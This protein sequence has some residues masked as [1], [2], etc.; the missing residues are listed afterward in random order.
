MSICLLFDNDGTLVDSERLS[1]I[2]YVRLF[3]NYDVA[4]DADELVT[5]Y[6][7][8][9]LAKIIEDIADEHNVIVSDNFIPQYRS[10]VADLF[11][12]ELKP[13]D[14]I[15]EALEQ[16]PYPKAVV[17]S[18][19]P[20]KIEQTLRICNL[21]DYFGKNIFSSYDLG[22][23]KPEP[24]IYL[25]AAKNMGY[26]PENCYAI[27]DSMAGLAA[28]SRAGMKTFFYNV[29]NEESPCESITSFT[30]MHDFPILIKNYQ[31]EQILV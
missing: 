8:M 26:S 1:S 4:L 5:K 27:E 7:G 17:S 31:T 18:G 12:Q 15:H 11:E 16:L 22:S 25:H 2:A 28:G 14:G 24:A 29:H 6:K 23:W 3:S 20:E 13:I 9:Q 30:S 21:T 10:I 19:P